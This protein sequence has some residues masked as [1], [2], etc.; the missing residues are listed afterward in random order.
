MS[1]AQDLP[2]IAGLRL[3]IRPSV[4]PLRQLHIPPWRSSM[5]S[6]FSALARHTG[7]IMVPR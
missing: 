4:G 7:A 2:T 6:R 5:S 3:L 1:A